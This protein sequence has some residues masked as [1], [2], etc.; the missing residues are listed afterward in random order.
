MLLERNI[1]LLLEVADLEI[2]LENIHYITDYISK[3]KKI[4]ILR[5]ITIYC[6]RTNYCLNNC[7]LIKSSSRQFM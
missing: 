5:K 1:R 4:H 6:L 7:E 2:L 3:D